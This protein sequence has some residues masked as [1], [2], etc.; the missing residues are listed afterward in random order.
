MSIWVQLL[1]INII[2]RTLLRPPS[3]ASSLEIAGIE[4]VQE[5]F[6]FFKSLENFGCVLIVSK[7]AI[8][9]LFPIYVL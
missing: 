5:D 6:L 1:E 7:D 4:A 9:K 8:H 2:R 3:Q